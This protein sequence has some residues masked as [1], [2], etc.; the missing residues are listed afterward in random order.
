MI[1]VVIP[2]F[3]GAAY[4]GQAIESVL[5][6]TLA[7]EEVVVVDDG[8]SDS[9]AQVVE[10]YAPGVLYRWQANQGPG[11]A[12][13]LG[14]RKSKGELL[15]FLDSDDLWLPEKLRLQK[16]AFDDDPELDLVFCQMSQF[17]ETG[18]DEAALSDEA[19]Q[20]SPLISCMLARRAAF[21][22]VGPLRP[23]LK[24]EFVDWYL[25]AREAG[26][27][28]RTLDVL[29]VKRR[30]HSANFT[31]LNKDMPREYLHLLKASLDRRRTKAGGAAP[32]ALQ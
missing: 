10:Q 16:A 27:R 23:D 5:V 24:A 29:L 8:S 9:T 21:E 25:R 28:M 2:V 19:A 31:L 14:I 18:P 1:S 17:R 3:N 30:L 15:A 11:A 22:R 12:R 26:L 7:P 32:S 4:I 13:N 6:Q 20:P